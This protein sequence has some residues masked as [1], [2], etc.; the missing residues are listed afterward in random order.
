MLPVTPLCVAPSDLSNQLGRPYSTPELLCKLRRVNPALHAPSDTMFPYLVKGAKLVGLYWG[1]PGNCDFS[2][3]GWRKK[4]R[5]ICSMPADFV[6]E[7]TQIGPDGL[8]IARGWRSALEKVIRSGAATRAALE[9]EFGTV[10]SREGSDDGAC[11]HCRKEGKTTPP[12]GGKEGMCDLHDS[13]IKAQMRM[14]EH[15]I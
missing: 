13:I 14:K 10:L 5:L 8:I 12:N 3:T 6:P 4:A 1:D 9:M 7:F 15:G 2:R 11:W